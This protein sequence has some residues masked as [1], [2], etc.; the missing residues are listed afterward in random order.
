MIQRLKFKEARKIYQELPNK[1]KLS[2]IDPLYVKND[3]FN[4]KNAEG[5]YL[6]YKKNNNKWI[7]NCLIGDI[8]NTNYKDIF[9]SYGYGGPVSNFEDEGFIND[10][11][12]AYISWAASN[13]VIAEF[14]RYNPIIK[15]S[16]FYFAESSF[17]RS[18]VLVDLKKTNIFESYKKRT[19][20]DIRKSYRDGVSI[21]INNKK[22]FLNC[23]KKLYLET[24]KRH[25]ADNFY[26]FNDDYFDAL[27]KNEN[28]FVATAILD[29]KEVSS[30]IFLISGDYMDYHLSGTNN[31]GLNANAN[32]ALL[33]EAMLYGKSLGIKFA[34]LGG[35][36]SQSKDDSLLNFK[37]GF[38]KDLTDFN[39]GKRILNS[40]IYN[41][42]TKSNNKILHWR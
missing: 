3:A 31:L 39:I 27:L 5:L 20:R 35:G 16:K 37:K 17:N 28:S 1:L 2:S 34:N 21:S 18:I 9:S 24:M 7:H 19:R 22:S 14:I 42:L 36:Y 6:L 23:F 15:N 25:S 4:Y 29:K 13:N 26:F 30:A 32:K 8:M 11:N 10:A 40:T 41:Q 33:H 12:E 38:S